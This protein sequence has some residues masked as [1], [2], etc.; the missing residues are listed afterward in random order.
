MEI[1]VEETGTR[2]ILTLGEE[3][4]LTFKNIFHAVLT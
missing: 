3:T 1:T 4:F 2:W